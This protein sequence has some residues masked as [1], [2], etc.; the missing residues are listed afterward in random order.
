MSFLCRTLGESLRKGAAKM[1]RMPRYV[2]HGLDPAALVRLRKKRGLT[3]DDLGL[4]LGVNTQSILNWESGRAAPSP[5]SFKRLLEVLQV[6]DKQIVAENSANDTL[7]VYRQRAGLTQRTA[8]SSTEIQ[9]YRF[10]D[11]ERGVRLPTREEARALA[12]AY[13][14]SVSKVETLCQILHNQRTGQC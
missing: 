5:Q 4:K 2:V 11:I 10:L 3:Q 9:R 13:G 6:T 14:I 7:A 12:K 1:D 8:I